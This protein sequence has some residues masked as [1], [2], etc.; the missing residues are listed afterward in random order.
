MK[1]WTWL[2]MVTAVA[3]LASG[4][5]G[6]DGEAAEAT[7]TADDRDYRFVVV[8]HG[9]SAD[10]FWSV[11]A[12]GANDAAADMG[13]R[14]E[15]QAPG[16]FDMVEMSQ[17]INAAVASAP[18]GLIVTIPDPGALGPEIRAAVAAGIP[19]VSMNSGAESFADLGVLAHVG[20]TEYEAGLIAGQSFAE[21]GVT[22]ALCIN[23]EVGNLALDL[24]CEGF[25]DGLGGDVEVIPVNLAD[26]TGAQAA[27]AGA[28]STRNPDGILTLGPTG[29][30]PTMAALEEV[31]QVGDVAF[32]TFDLS[33]EVLE[34]VADE[35]MLFA[36][37]Q[38]QYLQG[39]LPIVL[40]TKYL[41]TGA[42]PLGSVDRVILTGPQLV[43]AD[44]AAD[45]VDFS[46]RGLR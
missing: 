26:P 23:Q 16:T 19:V 46:A 3:V 36:I 1:R 41:E 39:Y 9:Q 24:R 42:L 40:L 30:G 2:S 27:V 37:D 5:G 12:N 21:E 15:Y 6:Q 7:V 20:Q 45:V 17:I 29:A 4:C 13:I 38:A 35:T 32:A 33:P 8:S 31:G 43:T 14:V 34:A 22:N 44:V 11:A 28:L 18:D 10:P 25:A